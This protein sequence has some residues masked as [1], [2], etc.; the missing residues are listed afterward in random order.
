MPHNG[1]FRELKIIWKM[2]I[3]S[4]EEIRQMR[5]FLSTHHRSYSAPRDTAGNRLAVYLTGH[6]TSIHL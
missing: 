4:C 3:I 5:P 1:I 2:N 6:E